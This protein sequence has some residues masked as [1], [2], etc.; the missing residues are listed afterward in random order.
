MLLIYFNG[1]TKIKLHELIKTMF[2]II[3]D[4]IILFRFII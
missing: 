4:E 2:N 3:N 1:N